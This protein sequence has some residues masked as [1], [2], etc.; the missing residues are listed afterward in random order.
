MDTSWTLCCSV[1]RCTSW[2]ESMPR[3]SPLIEGYIVYPVVAWVVVKNR[4]ILVGC[5]W[6]KPILVTGRIA[7]DYRIYTASLHLVV[8]AC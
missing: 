8:S 4:M 2:S 1:S 3:C 5:D 6:S 7:A